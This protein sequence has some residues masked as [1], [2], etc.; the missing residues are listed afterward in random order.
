MTIAISI[1]IFCGSMICQAIFI[2][3]WLFDKINWAW[4]WV[5]FP[6]LFLAALILFTII[7]TNVMNWRG[8]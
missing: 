6:L 8:D 4:Y 5:F 1:L 3:L 2:I 7:Y